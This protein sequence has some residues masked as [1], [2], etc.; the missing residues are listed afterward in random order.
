MGKEWE[1][2]PPKDDK[3]DFIEW[4]GARLFLALISGRKYS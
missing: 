3:P 4:Q 2:F 1:T